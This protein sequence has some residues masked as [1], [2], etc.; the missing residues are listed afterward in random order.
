MGQYFETSKRK[1]ERRR[2]VKQMIISLGVLFG[3]QPIGA[4]A[5]NDF[6][7]VDRLN[8]FRETLEQVHLLMLMDL[9]I[10]CIWETGN[11]K[12]LFANKEYDQEAICTAFYGAITSIGLSI[13]QCET[14]VAGLKELEAAGLEHT[15]MTFE[16]KTRRRIFSNTFR[17]VLRSPETE[18]SAI[19][20]LVKLL[21]EEIAVNYLQE[22][23]LV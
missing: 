12:D 23:A 13:Y 2:A 15:F 18:F 16:E 6:I 11:E 9:L 19:K 20:K 1:M 5:S 14:V 21:K 4:F 22:S 10:I 3:S 8:F 17:E 7:I